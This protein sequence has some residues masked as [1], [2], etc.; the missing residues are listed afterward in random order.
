M[1]YH[2]RL[3]LLTLALVWLLTG[4]FIAWQWAQEKHYKAAVL[5]A[6]L[7]LN[8][9]R[10]L[11]TF[12][13]ADSIPN[14]IYRLSL[15]TPGL[16]VTVVDTTGRVLFDN[17]PG[18]LPSSNH[19]D[20][21]E[22]AQ[23]LATGAGYDKRRSATTDSVY[24]YSAT[25]RGP[26]VARSAAHYD[27]SLSEML[28]ADQTL[29]WFMIGITLLVSVLGY[30]AMR[31]H[32]LTLAHAQDTRRVKRQ[33][34][35]SINHELKTPVAATKLCLETLQQHP[36]L[37]E[38]QRNS[39]VDKALKQTDRLTALLADVATLNRLDDDNSSIECSNV[40]LA[41]VVRKAA[42]EYTGDQYIPIRL[43]L[44][45]D[46]VISGNEQLLLMIVRNLLSNANAYS[47]GTIID[48]RLN[49]VP[50]TGVPRLI[51]ADNG[52]GVAPEHLDRIFERFYRVDKG[53]SRA[54]GGTGLGLAIVKNAAA[55]HSGTVTASATIPSGLTVSITLPGRG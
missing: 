32:R 13:T 16:R 50:A 4:A 24:F 36:T 7:Q 53:R 6:R 52:R 37:S 46:I 48:I 38:E 2:Y 15:P 12:A 54:K 44:D 39:L 40:S 33:L 34:T 28:A 18:P 47:E 10:V 23:A 43:H 22:I 20:R 25:A 26:L 49:R 55:F 19:L 41:K 3:F 1:K 21:P 42:Q 27:P 51:V 14:E 45:N 29:L 8:N 31:Q 30:I 9:E 17:T 35:L 5:N 11:D